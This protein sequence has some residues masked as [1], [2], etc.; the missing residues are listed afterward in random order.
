MAQT[1]PAN[2]RGRHRPPGQ[3]CLDTREQ[4]VTRQIAVTIAFCLGGQNGCEKL[5]AG[6]L[7]LLEQLH[8]GPHDLAYVLKTTGRD[9]LG[10][11]LLKVGGKNDAVHG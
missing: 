5:G 1:A 3:T 10:R 8:A 9:R 2:S 4:I 7:A 6:T 11:E